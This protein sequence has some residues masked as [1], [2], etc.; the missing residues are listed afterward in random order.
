MRQAHL[1]A[2]RS[3]ENSERAPPRK[4]LGRALRPQT[5]EPEGPGRTQ[6]AK[7][8]LSRVVRATQG[9]DRNAYFFLPWVL[10][11]ILVSCVFTAQE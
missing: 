3:R 4:A 7:T 8:P 9:R 10:P 11:G 6:A 5:Q 1:P 2:E